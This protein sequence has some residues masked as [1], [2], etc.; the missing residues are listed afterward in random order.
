MG[1]KFLFESILNKH[2]TE[3]RDE[4][5]DDDDDGKAYTSDD[6]DDAE[7]QRAFA[8]GELKPGLHGLVAYKRT[9]SLING[10]EGIIYNQPKKYCLKIFFCRTKKKTGRNTNLQRQLVGAP[11][12]NQ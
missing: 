11:R 7:L 9:E 1:K 4:D 6:S 12:P 5:E 3:E 8:A 10:V 2:S